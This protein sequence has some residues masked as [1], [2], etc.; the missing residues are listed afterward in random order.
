MAPL[1]SQ[2][3]KNKL[4]IILH[5]FRRQADLSS[6]SKNSNAILCNSCKKLNFDIAI[7]QAWI[8]AKQSYRHCYTNGA[9]SENPADLARGPAFQD[10]DIGALESVLSQAKS[11]VF[12]S[13]VVE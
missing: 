4:R 12:C 2:E 11:C 9:L 3:K 6:D 13:F 10:L 5:P 7:P 1:L 8:S